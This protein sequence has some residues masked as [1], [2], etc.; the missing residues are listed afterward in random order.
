MAST[1]LIQCRGSAGTTIA[2]LH[3]DIIETHLLPKF[4]GPSLAS[5]ASTCKF[6]TTLCNKQSLW[7][8]ICT[9]TWES[10][11]HPLVRQTISSFPG[12]Y[13]SFYSDSFPVLRPNISQG[14]FRQVHAAELISAVDMQLGNIPVYSKVTLTDTSASGF[15]G[16]LFCVDLIEHKETV[17]IPLKYQ[18]DEECM[19][20]LEESLTLS[21]I[22]IDP[23]LKRAANV[24]SLRPVSV[25]PHWDGN[26]IKVIYATVLSGESCGIETTKFVECRIVAIF[27][28]DEGKML[29][30]KELSLCVVDMVRTRLNGE[31]S[32]RIL[33]AALETGHRKRENGDAKIMYGK[34]LDFKRNMRDEKKGRG[35]KLYRAL[36]VFHAIIWVFFVISLISSIWFA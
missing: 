33:E 34:Y 28:C 31:K 9:S 17:E 30:L 10:I 11:K 25:R 22:V 12:G 27:T 14:R 19:S 3:S 23:T 21:W 15:L 36:W 32:L 2:A 7:E 4:D 26:G 35:D 8:H 13:H 29:Q 24:S 5:A 1:S 6:F 18:G 16:S 20:K